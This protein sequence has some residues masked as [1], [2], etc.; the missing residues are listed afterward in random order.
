MLRNFRSIVLLFT[1]SLTVV[2]GQKGVEFL[3]PTPTGSVM[4]EISVVDKN[5]AWAAGTLGTVLKTTDAGKTW[6]QVKTGEDTWYTSIDAVSPEK[7]FLTAWNKYL[8]STTDG[9]KTWKSEQIGKLS[10]LKRSNLSMQTTVFSSA[11]KNLVKMNLNPFSN[12]GLQPM[13]EQ[14]GMNETGH[15]QWTPPISASFQQ[16]LVL[17]Q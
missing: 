10:Y 14:H 17:L 1:L 3:S 11:V 15:S 12:S 2:F 13:A 16:K 4:V 9:G 6:Q 7:V 5:T 8:Q